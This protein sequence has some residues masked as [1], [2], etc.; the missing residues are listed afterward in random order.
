TYPRQ[1]IARAIAAEGL[2]GR[3]VWRQYVPDEELKTLYEEAG[4]FAF[5]SEYEGFGLTPLEALASGVPPLL[6]DTAVAREICAGAALY[7]SRG[8]SADIPHSPARLPCDAVTRAGSMTC[9]TPV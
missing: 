1:D 2:D 5:L 6:L 7:V 9:T 4:A 8:A 3:A